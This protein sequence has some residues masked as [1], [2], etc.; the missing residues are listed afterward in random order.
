MLDFQVLTRQS[1]FAGERL[2]LVERTHRALCRSALPHLTLALR[3]AVDLELVGVEPRT[4]D[5]ALDEL[6]EHALFASLPAAPLG[7]TLLLAADSAGVLDLVTRLLGGSGSGSRGRLP[8]EIELVVARRV[9]DA[10]VQA[11]APA[12][13]ELLGLDLS[14]GTVDV[15]PPVALA[16]AGEPC[17]VIRHTLDGSALSLVVPWQAIE[18]LAE[19]LPPAAEPEPDPLVAFAEVELQAEVG[20][21]QLTT[22]A[23]A[24]LAEGDLLSLGVPASAGVTLHVSGLPL[25]RGQPGRSGR[26][27]AIHVVESLA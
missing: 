15:D 11:L 27:R 24:A 18:Q 23:F 8:T 14:L 19:R 7:T 2:E 6:P 1:P 13:Q 10:L 21:M 5:E 4:W 16:P 3:G 9:L 26:R 17:L 20:S 22:D 12:W 25:H